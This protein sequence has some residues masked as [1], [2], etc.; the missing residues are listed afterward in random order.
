MSSPSTAPKPH[1]SNNDYTEAVI[2]FSSVILALATI[3]V[4]A[5]CLARLNT[6][7]IR[8]ALDDGFVILSWLGFMGT[9]V[10]NIILAQKRM[11][12]PYT[13]TS[14]SP[15]QAVIGA[16]AISSVGI[17]YPVAVTGAKLS[18]LFLFRRVFGMRET[19]FRWAWWGVMALI[20]AWFIVAVTWGSLGIAKVLA[21][22]VELDYAIPTVATM[23]TISD[24]FILTLPMGMTYKLHLSLQQRASVMLVF[25]LGSGGTI[26]SLVRCIRNFRSKE[27]DWDG[28]YQLFCET[29]LGT[30]EAGVILICACLPVMR[31]LFRSVKG[32]AVTTFG[33]VTGRTNYST[34]SSGFR[35]R[36]A[37]RG[38]KNHISLGSRE[39]GDS[40]EAPINLKEN[41]IHR[42]IDVDVDSRSRHSEQ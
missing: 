22:S 23:N 19:W 30:A 20:L 24:I 27:Q 8:V 12:A 32:F 5:R 13:L 21:L 7:D 36:D 39:F 33:A 38:T 41:V 6:K 25:L 31:P 18:L 29:M 15:S 37:T 26:V 2:A 14:P 3:A 17:T 9:C 35:S 16:S 4:A 34:S 11:V 10:A 28:R 1:A 42:R 40:D